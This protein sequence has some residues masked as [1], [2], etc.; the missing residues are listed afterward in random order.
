MVSQHQGTAPEAFAR[1]VR[2]C[3]LKQ[4]GQSG[5]RIWSPPRVPPYG[6]SLKAWNLRL[7]YS[8]STGQHLRFANSRVVGYTS[9]GPDVR[10][11]AAISRYGRTRALARHPIPPFLQERLFDVI[12]RLTPKTHRQFMF[13]RAQETED[14]GV[15]MRPRMR[16]GIK[17]SLLAK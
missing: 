3:A 7:D 4:R 9:I 13:F 10:G 16:S 2:P 8:R 1:I 17:T 5:V 11:A 15:F 6:V 12:T 14:A